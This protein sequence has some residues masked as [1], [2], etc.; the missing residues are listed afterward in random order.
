VGL[1]LGDH[2]YAR[3]TILAEELL[4]RVKF[5]ASENPIDRC[6]IRVSFREITSSLCTVA[7]ALK[8]RTELRPKIFRDTG[9]TRSIITPLERPLDV[10]NLDPKKIVQEGYLQLWH[11]RRE[12]VQDALE[13]HSDIA[14]LKFELRKKLLEEVVQCVSLNDIDAIGCATN[15]LEATLLGK[16]LG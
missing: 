13:G 2:D 12:W 4:F 9:Q 11:H 16:H 10:T 15:A 7:Q 6:D 3:S 1:T 5:F 14:S 8:F